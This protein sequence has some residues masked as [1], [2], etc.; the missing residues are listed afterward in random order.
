MGGQRT[1]GQ[2]QVGDAQSVEVAVGDEF[3]IVLAD[4]PGAG[5]EWVPRDEPPGLSLLSSAVRPDVA[6][7][8]TGASTPRTFRYTGREPGTYAL[9]FDLLRPWE[10]AGTEPAAHHDVTVLVRRRS[11]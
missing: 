4:L 1:D 7:S 9:G 3:V 5:Y 10:P 8:S 11:P 2:D 6:P